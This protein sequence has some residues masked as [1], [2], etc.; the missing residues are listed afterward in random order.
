MLKRLQ[1]LQHQRTVSLLCEAS[2]KDVIQRVHGPDVYINLAVDQ[3]QND[4]YNVGNHEIHD[5]LRHDRTARRHQPVPGDRTVHKASDNSSKKPGKKLT[6]DDGDQVFDHQAILALLAGAGSKSAAPTRTAG[7]SVQRNDST[8]NSHIR[9]EKHGHDTGHTGAELNL[10]ESNSLRHMRPSAHDSRTAPDHLDTDQKGDEKP[11]IISLS[12]GNL[13]GTWDSSSGRMTS[14]DTIKKY[15]GMSDVRGTGGQPF[16]LGYSDGNQNHSH[17]TDGAHRGSHSGNSGRKM[18]L[19]RPE[20]HEERDYVHA[21]GHK[22]RD[23]SGTKRLAYAHFDTLRYHAHGQDHVHDSSTHVHARDTD[24]GTHYGA[25]VQRVPKIDPF[26]QKFTSLRPEFRSGNM[27][28]RSGIEDTGNYGFVH[29]GRKIRGGKSGQGVRL[30]LAQLFANIYDAVRLDVVCSACDVCV[31][32][33]DKEKVV[34]LV[35]TCVYFLYSVWES[36]FQVSQ[37]RPMGVQHLCRYT[38]TVC[39]TCMDV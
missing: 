37:R 7:T 4:R 15:L 25:P 35:W 3:V 26:E 9:G 14:F 5:Y 27:D 13:A 39:A 18:A 11:R 8:Q 34:F 6:T 38:H 12:R 19:Q 23:K 1:T 36:R 21:D 30:F 22:M 31:C 17:Y 29:K 20:N 24:V 16:E 10:D 33:C 28:A 32:V 2:P